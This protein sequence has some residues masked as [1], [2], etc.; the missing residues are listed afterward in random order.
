MVTSVQIGRENVKLVLSQA[1]GKV[2]IADEQG[3]HIRRP[4][5]EAKNNIGNYA[6]WMITNAEIGELIKYHLNDEDKAELKKKLS[7]I[8][9]YLKGS[10]FAIRSASKTKLEKKFMGFEIYEYKENFYSFEKELESK[11]KI[12]LTFKMGDYTLAVHM[13]VLL[14]FRKGIITLH[15]YAGE[16]REHALLSSGCYAVWGPTKDELKEIVEALS[17]A[18]E[19]HKKDL[20]VMLV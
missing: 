18:S 5:Q 20:L 10:E 7:S 1:M 14:P 3:N 17:C 11:I 4:T 16:V 8:K 15:N 19:D 6:E 13:F 9:T 12:R 2:R